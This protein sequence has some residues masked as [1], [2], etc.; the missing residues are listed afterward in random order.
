M[1]V[2]DF[3]ANPGIHE[4]TERVYRTIVQDGVRDYDTLADRLGDDQE[5]V[6]SAIDELARVGLVQVDAGVLEPPGPAPTRRSP[7]RPSRSATGFSVS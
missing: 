6:R 2:L 3:S 1:S 5:T 7:R 4:L